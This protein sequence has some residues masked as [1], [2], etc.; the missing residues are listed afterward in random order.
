[1]N[2]VIHAVDNSPAMVSRLRRK[3]E[4][5]DAERQNL[6]KVELHERNILDFKLVNA[7]FVVLNWTLQFVPPD[8]RATVLADIYQAILPGGALLLSEKISFSQAGE[9][10]LL[11]DLHHDFKRSHGYSELE[12]AQKRQAL[13][14]T[15]IPETIEVH[16]ERLRKCGFA[17]VAPWFQCFNFASFLAIKEIETKES[18]Q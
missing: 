2:C 1:M 11:T 15:M 10:T 7:S 13:E 6:R 12:I 8:F 18:A 16:C 5:M 3:L 14:N 17:I 9:Q 4:G